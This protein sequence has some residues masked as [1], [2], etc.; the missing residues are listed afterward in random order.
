MSTKTIKQRIAVLAAA[1]LG[2]GVLSATPAF[3]VALVADDVNI[4]STTFDSICVVAAG[5]ETAYVPVTSQ[6]VSILA[7]AAGVADDETAFF[8]ISGPA[9]WKSVVTGTGGAGTIS[10]GQKEFELTDA[11][12][13]D[14]AGAVL[15]PTGVG[16][17]TVTISA[18]SG[19]TAIDSL[20]IYVVA[21]CGNAAWNATN[22]KVQMSTTAAGN[23]TSNVDVDTSAIAGTPMYIKL[24]P[25]DAYGTAITS[26][27]L[28]ATATNNALLAWGAAAAGFPVGVG[29]VATS[30]PTANHQ[31]RVDPA[32][33]A[34][35]STT[36][37]TITLNGT[38]VATKTITFHG[39]QAKIVIGTV[40]AGKT[41]DADD[42]AFT[43]TYQ[44]SAGNTVPG[45]AA[46]G[47]AASYGT[48]LKA[49][50]SV[51]APTISSATIGAANDV[52]QA[53]ITGTTGGKTTAGVMVYECGSSAGTADVTIATTSTVN[54]NTLTATVTGKC[55]GSVSTYTV[56]TDK[57]K[58]NIGD[59]AIITIEAKDSSGN[60]VT[61][62]AQLQAGSVSVGGGD[63]T[64][65]ILGTTAANSST[66]A[67]EGFQNGIVKLRAQMK[68]AGTFNAV[69]AL[70]G[71][72]VDSATAS[73][74]VIDPA[75]VGAVSN[76]EVLKSIV[77]LIASI[78]KQIAALQKLILA[79]K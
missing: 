8:T 73:Y 5:N 62:T 1:A 53:K 40:Y 50:T 31:L 56:A 46:A 33:S 10:V 27:L 54:A 18:T 71:T 68:T 21:T 23:A 12:T 13:A 44:D 39:E 45:N 76:A 11:G 72:K 29:S 3:A 2:F 65:T 9:V 41:S 64:Y 28:M 52:T 17:V 36:T 60:P 6:G 35:T 25:V 16:T 57:A 20:T 34:T 47:V 37:V 14:D 61:D 26:G 30:V 79:K 74:T 15:V 77:A 78:N 4:A 58:Y 43:F 67:I 48:R 75:T 22:S 59:I 63:L 51:K 42:G 66:G 24:Q 55:Y 70:A 49:V 32:Q 19:G 7:N 69:V 38:A